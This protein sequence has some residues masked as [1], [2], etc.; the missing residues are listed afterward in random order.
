MRESSFNNILFPNIF[1]E[2]FW[3]FLGAFPCCAVHTLSVTVSDSLFSWTMDSAV[4]SSLM[5]AAWSCNLASICFRMSVSHPASSLFKPRTSKSTSEDNRLSPPSGFIKVWHCRQRRVPTCPLCNRN[6]QME[7][8]FRVP[9]LMHKLRVWL[10]YPLQQDE[11]GLDILVRL[12]FAWQNPARPL[13]S[14][15]RKAMGA[16]CALGCKLIPAMAVCMQLTQSH[17]RPKPT[18]GSME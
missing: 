7:V 14:R 5:H 11:A 16:I 9:R 10:T 8:Q 1:Y 13:W 2:E 4:D 6:I 15:N 12:S 17:A 18:A 3:S